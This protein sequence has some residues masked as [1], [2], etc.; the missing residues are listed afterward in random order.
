MNTGSLLARVAS[1][2]ACNSRSALLW[3]VEFSVTNRASAL[4]ETDSN[5]LK[6]TFN[7]SIVPLR[8]LTEKLAKVHPGCSSRQPVP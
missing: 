3:F 4:Y 5:I 6:S 2:S 7:P 8:G 1:Y